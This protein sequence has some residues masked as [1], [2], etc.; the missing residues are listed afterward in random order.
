LYERAFL[1]IPV[2][3]VIISLDYWQ[4]TTGKTTFWQTGGA[5][6]PDETAK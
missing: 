1:I 4:N 3:L 2:V 6:E 5:T